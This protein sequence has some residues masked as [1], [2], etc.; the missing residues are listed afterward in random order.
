[1]TPEKQQTPLQKLIQMVNGRIEFFESQR[2]N[3]IVN[4]LNGIKIKAE[5]LL[6]EEKKMVIDTCRHGISIDAGALE[7]SE[8]NNYEEQYFNET[9]NETRP[10]KA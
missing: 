4:I 2:E 8:I 10:T 1:M 9:Y 6:P 7:N 3:N 5:S